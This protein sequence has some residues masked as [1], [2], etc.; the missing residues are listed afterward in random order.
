MTRRASVRL[1]ALCVLGVLLSNIPRP[2]TAAPPAG[3]NWDNPFCAAVAELVP[4]NRATNT[5]TDGPTDSYALYLWSSALSNF[6]VRMTFVDSDSAY[7]ADVPQAT[8]PKDKVGLTLRWFFRITFDHPVSL[9]DQFVDAVSVDGGAMTNCPSFVRQV[10]SLKNR[11]GTLVR[12]TEDGHA[13]AHFLQRL[14]SL[15][16]GKTFTPVRAKVAFSPVVGHFGDRPLSADIEVFVD[17]DGRVVKTR[18]WHSS[19]VD[20]IDDA[21]MGAAQLTTYEPAQFLCIPVVNHG[22]FRLDYRG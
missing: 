10:F 7:T 2:S 6:S 22:V 21:A 12:E 5:T 11:T 17:S 9:T 20:G 16:C 19:G 13:T 14:P 1:A 4:L 15:P 18:I 8:I 3:V